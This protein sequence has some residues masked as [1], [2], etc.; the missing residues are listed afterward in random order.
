MFLESEITIV[1]GLPRSGT[2]PLGVPVLPPRL[3]GVLKWK[4]QELSVSWPLPR[5]TMRRVAGWCRRGNYRRPSAWRRR[6]A[7]GN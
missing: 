2:S 3:P 5:D 4:G 7:G 1:S 6:P